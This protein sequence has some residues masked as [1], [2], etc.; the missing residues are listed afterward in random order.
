MERRDLGEAL[1]QRGRV[2]SSF[3]RLPLRIADVPVAQPASPCGASGEGG[4]GHGTEAEGKEFG[5]V[6]WCL[7]VRRCSDAL[8]A[9]TKCLRGKTEAPSLAELVRVDEARAA[10][11]V[12]RRG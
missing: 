12:A 9:T 3:R 1:E 8:P 6:S 7:R 5:Q 2:Q 4:T 10:T 11:D